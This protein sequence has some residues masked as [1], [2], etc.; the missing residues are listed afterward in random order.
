MSRLMAPVPAIP[1]HLDC[2][3]KESPMTWDFLS[4]SGEI[5]SGDIKRGKMFT[6]I[7]IY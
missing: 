6:Q 1:S 7:R 3:D 4:V 2:E 5:R